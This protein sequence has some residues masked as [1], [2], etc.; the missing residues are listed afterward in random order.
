M[1]RGG[2]H[3]IARKEQGQGIH[4]SGSDVV[5]ANVRSTGGSSAKAIGQAA[6][7]RTTAGNSKQEGRKQNQHT[8]RNQTKE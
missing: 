1:T 8:G 2:E 6:N 5:K 7:R 4:I 3:K